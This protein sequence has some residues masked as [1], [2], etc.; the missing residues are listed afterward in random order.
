MRLKPTNRIAVTHFLSGFPFGQ[1]TETFLS[2]PDGSMDD[3][4]EKLSRPRIKNEDGAVDWLRRQVTL[5]GL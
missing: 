3:L 2:G 1:L 4:E 5:E